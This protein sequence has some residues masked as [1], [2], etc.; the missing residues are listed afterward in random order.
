MDSRLALARELGATHTIN[1]TQGDAETLIQEALAG[2]PLDVFIDNTGVPSL[3]ELGYRITHRHGRVILVGVPRLGDNINVLFP[4]FAFRQSAHWFPRWRVPA[5]SRYPPL[6]AVDGTAQFSGRSL[7]ECSLPVGRDQCCHC[8]NAQWCNCWKGDD[9][10]VNSP[11]LQIQ[12]ASALRGCVLAYGHFTTIHPGHIRY[13]RHARSLGQELVVAVIGDPDQSNPYP[14][15]QRERADAVSLLGLAAAVLLL[16]RDELEQVIESLQPSI[17][18]LGSDL[19]GD[20]RSQHLLGLLRGYGGSLQFHAG[21]AT[22][23]STDLLNSSER[24]LRQ[25][26]REQFNASCRRQTWAVPSWR[27]LCSPGPKHA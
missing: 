25:Q 26:R 18:V 8:C 24:D 27:P 17:L 16:D 7:C 6:S 15:S 19:E 21:E 12:D 13:L 4:P 20:Q 1:S 5:R 3:I 11:L 10:A 23:A 14:F 2:Q 9:H 22:Y